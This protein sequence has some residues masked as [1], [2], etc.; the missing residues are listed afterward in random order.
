MTT[1][2]LIQ[3]CSKGDLALV[4]RFVETNGI[5]VSSSD[6]DARTPLHLAAGEGRLG[7]VMV[8]SLIHI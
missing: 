1:Y 8:L 5:A 2:D 7:V 4:Q 6:Y 3:A